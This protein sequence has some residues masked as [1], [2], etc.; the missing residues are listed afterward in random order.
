MLFYI[1]GCMK[2]ILLFI[3]FLLLLIGCKSV[4]ISSSVSTSLTEIETI[5]E[6]I[7]VNDYSDSTKDNHKKM[8]DY[9]LQFLDNPIN[10]KI[11]VGLVNFGYGKVETVN[12][13]KPSELKNKVDYQKTTI[14][15]T[16][17]D[18]EFALDQAI[19]MFDKD[20][21]IDK[22]IILLTDAM[23][24]DGNLSSFATVLNHNKIKLDVIY[25]APKDYSDTPEAQISGL[26]IANDVIPFK[27]TTIKVSLRSHG[28]THV[29]LTIEDNGK[30]IF[31]TG[32]SYRNI[33]LSKNDS[34]QEFEYKYTFDQA[35]IHELKAE[36]SPLNSDDLINENNIFYSYAYLEALNEIL[37]IASENEDSTSLTK[38]IESYGY[39][40]TVVTPMNTPKTLGELTK[41]KEVILMNANMVSFNSGFANLLK[42]YVHD[43][44]G[45]VLT[46]G[47]ENTYLNG[48][49]KNSP[50]EDMLPI[51]LTNSVS[52]PRAFVICLDYSNSMGMYSL[53]GQK[54]Y[55]YKT[56]ET[57]IRD[58]SLQVENTRIKVAIKAIEETI[59]TSLNP[60]DYLG[61]ITFG[62]ATSAEITDGYGG[63]TKIIFGLT[64]VTQKKEMIE[65]IEQNVV[66]DNIKGGTCYDSALGYAE[67][68]LLNLPDETIKTKEII[69][70]NDYDAS[71]NDHVRTYKSTIERCKTKGISLQ[72]L[73]IGPQHT[74]YVQEMSDI[75]PEKNKIYHTTDAKEFANIFKDL[76]K[77]IPTKP[78]TSLKSE[79]K[80]EFTPGTKLTA[81]IDPYALPTFS[82]YNGG[83]IVKSE[84]YD[85][86]H[87]T[88]EEAIYDENGNLIDTYSNV[89]PIYA[90]WEYGI[91]KVG[92]LMIDLSGKWCTDF[93]TNANSLKLLRNIIT[94]LLPEEKAEILSIEVDKFLLNDSDIIDELKANYMHRLEIKLLTENFDEENENTEGEETPEVMPKNISLDVIISR[95]DYKTNKTSMVENFKLESSSGNIFSRDFETKEPGLYRIDVIAYIDGNKVAE[96]SAYVAFS[97]SKE[98]DTFLN[99]YNYVS[100]LEDLCNYTSGEFVR[101]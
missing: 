17:T 67:S 65:K 22:K 23:D 41:Y 64:K 95:F 5:N 84:E 39:I 27:E 56:D 72:S 73:V 1:G 101:Y 12:L 15:K 87:F 21:K 19:S 30:T 32:N 91:G 82:T 14:D 78:V 85:K 44:G 61:L 99:N 36:I 68:M 40:P 80:F 79:G 8:D 74:E 63:D 9:I 90:E 70:V 16:G 49:M 100:N 97:Y 83:V 50:M 33:K 98:Y 28:N 66:K 69:L 81:G 94:G 42:R 86:I 59:N 46:A 26:E 77:A 13:T 47:G 43:A 38:A 6:V 51:N 57:I 58:P 75:W 54:L 25:F 71:N 52:N 89:N 60:N 37:I 48:N 34:V 3:S 45:N 35:G 62:G 29:K 96:K 55:D 10:N 88:N 24:T 18:I 11:K 7:F 31:S 93:Y 76:F 53:D 20:T 4:P 92:S 2:K